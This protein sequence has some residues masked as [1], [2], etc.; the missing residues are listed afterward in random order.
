MKLRA[1]E[2]CTYR[3]DLCSQEEISL[4]IEQV[5]VHSS[6]KPPTGFD[7]DSGSKNLSTPHKDAD[8]NHWANK[9]DVSSDILDV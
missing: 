8:D 2:D 7:K 1:P 5:E 6:D 3:L 4:H 9:I